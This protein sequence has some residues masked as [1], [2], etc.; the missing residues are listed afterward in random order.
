MGPMC[1]VNMKQ[2]VVPQDRCRFPSLHGL[3]NY[4]LRMEGGR[5]LVWQDDRRG[6]HPSS[7]SGCRS[8]RDCIALG[9]PPN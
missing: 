9:Q 8:S 3:G 5:A 6:L 7:A 4:F 1:R 2:G